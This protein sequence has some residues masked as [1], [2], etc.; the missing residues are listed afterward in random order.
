[1]V[2]KALLPYPKTWSLEELAER[3]HALRY[4]ERYK[5]TIPAEERWLFLRKSILYQLKDMQGNGIIRE[6]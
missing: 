4:E 6:L 2:Y 3:C 1:M 5:K